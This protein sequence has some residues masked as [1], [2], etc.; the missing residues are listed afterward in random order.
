IDR[1]DL[2]HYASEI[3]PVD[4]ASLL[5]R[6]PELREFARIELVDFG[7]H[8]GLAPSDWVRLGKS[9]YR[10][11]ETDGFD[12]AVVTHGTNTLEETAYF[13]GLTVRTEKPVVVA[14]AM[15]PP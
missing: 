2:G 1:L 11:L 3:R 15:R 4:P 7:W 14:G 5:E 13:L 8:K 9:L 12:G 10:L 6:V